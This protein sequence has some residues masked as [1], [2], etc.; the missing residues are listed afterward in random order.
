M[1]ILLTNADTRKI[2]NSGP[3]TITSTQP[4]KQSITINGV[5]TPHLT[6][7]PI[8]SSQAINNNIKQDKQASYSIA[9]PK[10]APKNA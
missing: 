10:K 4:F 8:T 5:I 9:P 2:L 1:Q 6:P 3:H 7:K